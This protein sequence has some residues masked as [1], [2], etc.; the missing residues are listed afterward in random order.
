MKISAWRGCAPILLAALAASARAEAPADFAATMP[1][2][3]QGGEA[4]QR[5]ELPVAVYANAQ[6][7]D[8][9]DVRIFNAANELVPHALIGDAPPPPAV[10]ESFSPPVFPVWGVPGKGIEQLDVRIEQRQDGTVASI[11][12]IGAP[13]LKPNAPGHPINYIID[14]SAVTLP[15]AVMRPQWQAVP[16]N[17]IGNARIEAS[18]D[19]KTWRMLVG[20][21][22]LVYLTQGQTRLAQDRILLPPTKAKYFRVTFGANAPLLVALQMEAPALRGEPRRQAV[23]VGGRAGEKPNEIVY[24]LGVRAPVDRLRIDV[25]QTNALAPVR[26]ESRADARAEWRPVT[27]TIAYRLVRDAKEVASPEVPI[28]LNTARDWRLV[29]DPASGGLGTPPPE[30]E[31]S[32][33]VRNLVFLARGG[34]PF[35]LAVGKKDAVAAALPIASLIPGYREQGETS[36]P[37]ASV[38]DVRMAPRPAPPFLPTVLGEQDPKK[39]GLWAALLVGVA[40][41]AAMAWRLSRQMQHKEVPKSADES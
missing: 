14:A 23:H 5:V 8:L 10:A 15:I 40:L 18:D 33:P 19:L 7:A 4:L 21:A 6:F 38:G 1:L 12:T 30:L 20:D 2:V 9:R 39:V 25:R 3:A 32:W 41:L 36:L 26:I 11:R 13:A 28:A 24:D 17:Y 16:E 35:T 22:S 31:A 34:G 27:S 29:V 37:A